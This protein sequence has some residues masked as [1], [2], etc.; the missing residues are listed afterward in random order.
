MA[1]LV[2]D[3]GAYSYVSANF[4]SNRDMEK[5]LHGVVASPHQS[6]SHTSM[7]AHHVVSTIAVQKAATVLS[8][9]ITNYAKK[10]SKGLE[11]KFTEGW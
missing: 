5:T 11:K 3:L 2:L 9:Q 8:L 4:S 1:T 10:C 7:H 6:N